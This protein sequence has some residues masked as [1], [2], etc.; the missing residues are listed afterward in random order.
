[1]TKIRIIPEHFFRIDY[2]F[3]MID[4]SLK[5]YL[6]SF[7]SLFDEIDIKKIFNTS[8]PEKNVL[9]QLRQKTKCELL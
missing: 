1:M 8:G 4:S 3:L 6:L 9:C 7:L 5:H 2:F